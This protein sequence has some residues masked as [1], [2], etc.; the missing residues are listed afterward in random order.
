G[1]FGQRSFGAA[2]KFYRRPETGSGRTGQHLRFRRTA[3]LSALHASGGIS[4]AERAGSADWRKPRA[5]PTLAKEEGAGENASQS[6]GF[7]GKA[8]AQRGGSAGVGK[9]E[10]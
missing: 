7:A 6:S 8:A 2:G 1:G 3:G 4:R 5:D 9:S 10:Q